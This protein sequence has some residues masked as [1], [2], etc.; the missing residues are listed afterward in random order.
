MTAAAAAPDADAEGSASVP[1][2]PRKSSSGPRV[3][4]GRSAPDGPH[5][6]SDQALY[7]QALADGGARGELLIERHGLDREPTSLRWWLRDPDAGPPHDVRA[8]DLVTSGPVLD[9]GCATGRHLELLAGRGVEAEGIDILAAA[10]ELARRHGC[11]ARVADIWTFRPGRQYRHLLLLGHNIGIPG[12]L[13][14]LVPFL[15][16]LGELLRSDGTVILSGRDWRADSRITATPTA[17]GTGPGSGYPGDTRLRHHYG[18]ATGPWFDWLDVDPDT[19]A[20]QAA[21]A[22]FC[23]RFARHGTGRYLAELAK[24]A[25]RDPGRG[26]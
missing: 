26:V 5:A 17:S 19:L 18:S 9:I 25:G 6:A 8:L 16:R 24:V 20:A 12:R 23:V 21:R 4:A 13:A 15:R 3:P 7:A 11:R 22:G 1:D 2:S 14:R 10:T